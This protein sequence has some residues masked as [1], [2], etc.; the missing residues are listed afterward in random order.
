MRAATF[1]DLNDVIV[2]GI[3]IHAA[4]AGCDFHRSTEEVEEAF[5]STQPMRAAT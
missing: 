1:S 3:S 2:S 5:Q 4:H